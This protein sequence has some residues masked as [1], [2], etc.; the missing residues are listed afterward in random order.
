M[1]KVSLG[2]IL[3]GNPEC[4]QKPRA[5]IKILAVIA[6]FLWIPAGVAAFLTVCFCIAKNSGYLLRIAVSLVVFA[7]GMYACSLLWSDHFRCPYCRH[8]GTQKQISDNK[9]ISSSNRSVSRRVHESRSGMIYDWGRDTTFYTSNSSHKEYGTET[10]KTYTF[11][12]RCKRCGCVHKVEKTRTST[13][14]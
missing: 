8:F 4:V 2:I 6:K 14:Y 11:N 5:W 3:P 1:E 7:I 13:R 9:T 10:T 12:M